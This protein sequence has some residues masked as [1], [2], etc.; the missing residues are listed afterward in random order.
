MSFWRNRTKNHENAE[1][2]SE[3]ILLYCSASKVAKIEEKTNMHSADTKDEDLL[4]D[5]FTDESIVFKSVSKVLS[6]NFIDATFIVSQQ[7]V[8]LQETLQDM[9]LVF[10]MVLRSQKFLRYRMPTIE[11]E[12]S[13]LC[14][15]FSVEDLKNALDR[16][17][18]TDHFRMY[19]RADE[20]HVLH[21]EIT[22]E[23]KKSKTHKFITLKNTKL[24]DVIPPT[25]VDHQ[26]TVVVSST[27]FKKVTADAYKNSKVKIRIYAQK[28]GCMIEGTSSQIRGN[29]DL[30]GTWDD[31]GVVVYDEIISTKK[32]HSFAEMAIIS[33]TKTI[34]IYACEQNPLRLNADAGGLGRVS[35][36]IQ[37][38]SE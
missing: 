8:F 1:G 32:F 29:Q 19:I 14:L 7:G 13:V 17:T 34:Q 24:S 2:F 35:L 30:F 12:G 11:R 36:Y 20:P 26:P 22:N 18:K 10:E 38:S 21:M 27:H 15:G 28:T 3:P 6:K 33:V 37:P 9:T 4:L 31:K 23:T 16:I 5:I 25:Y